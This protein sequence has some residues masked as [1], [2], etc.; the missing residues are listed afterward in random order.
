MGMDKLAKEALDSSTGLTLPT[1]LHYI[2][3]ANLYTSFG[4]HDLA[5]SD[6]NEA[7]RIN[8]AMEG[9]YRALSSDLEV[10]GSNP[11]NLD[12]EPLREESAQ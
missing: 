3:R 12:L 10:I 9:D 7:I 8:P 6:V 5:L 4:N 2:G 1:Y 11:Q